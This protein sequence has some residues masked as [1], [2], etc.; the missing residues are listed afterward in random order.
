[1]TRMPLLA[2]STARHARDGADCSLAGAIG[3]VALHAQLVEEGADVDDHTAAG[4]TEVRIGGLA[5]RHHG[6][7]IGVHHLL[8]VLQRDLRRRAVEVDSGVVHQPHHAPAFLG[9]VTKSSHQRAGLGY[10]TLQADPARGGFVRRASD[11]GKRT[12]ARDA[13]HVPP[14]CASASAMAAPMPRLAPG[15]DDAL[16]L[17][18]VIIAELRLALLGKGL[19]ALFGVAGAVGQRR[20]V[21]F[22]AQSLVQRHVHSPLH[23]LAAELQCAQAVALKTRGRRPWPKP[24]PAPARSG[25]RGRSPERFLG[26]HGAARHDHFQRATLPH[27]ARQALRATVTGNQA[28]LH[29]RQ[30]ELGIR[31]RQAQVQAS[32]SSQPPPKAK[33]LTSAIDGIGRRSSSANTDCPSSAPSRCAA[34]GRCCSSLMS[35]PAQKAFSPSPVTISARALERPASLMRSPMSRDQLEAERVE[36]LSADGW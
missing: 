31:K 10:V 20:Q 33:P 5:G 30:A 24:G 18:M 21:G 32:A 1:M 12:G 34:S 17:F 11:G 14:C 9:Q 25:S 28:Q 15:D 8:P 16:T 29:F 4:R 23:R 36:R 19:H 6:R 7:G 22:D 2:H 13:G 26:I 27:Q 35:A 3:Q